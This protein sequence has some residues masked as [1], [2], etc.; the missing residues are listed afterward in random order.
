MLTDREREFR[1]RPRKPPAV[2]RGSEIG[3]W[4][5]LYKAVMRHARMTRKTKHCGR[6]SGAIHGTKRFT[7]RCAVRVTYSRNTVKGQWGA[8]GRYVARDS[9]AGGD[10]GKAGGFDSGA[11]SNAIA[12]R[13]GGWQ[14]AGDERMWKLIVSPEFGERIDL[15]RLTRELMG[16]IEQALGD[17]SLEWVAA[18]HH[19]TEHPHVHIALRGVDKDGHA[20]RLNR[21]FIKRGMREIAEDLCTRQLGYRTQLDAADAE[22]GE[23]NQYRYT[24]LDRA[25][26]R[27][28]KSSE[29]TEGGEFLRVP[30]TDPKGAGRRAGAKLPDQHILQRLIALR[31]MGLAEPVE[32]NEWRV[33]RD[34]EAVLRSMQKIGDRQKTLT[35][36]GALMS[37]P[38]LTIESMDGRDWEVLEGRVL[39]HGE[40]EDG[41]DA[42]RSYL[43]LEGTDARVHHVTYTPEIEESRNRGQLRTNSFVRLRRYIV[44][45]TPVVESEDLG[46]A[47][48]ILRNKPHLRDTAR[49]LVK[50]GVIPEE[51]G[52][53]GWL[54]RYQAALRQTTQELGQTG[55]RAAERSSGQ[56]ISRGR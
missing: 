48:A 42:G 46:D 43:M 8:H 38:R 3:A 53:G 52:W 39:V 14:Q 51:G 34:F 45:G 36:H 31:R 47:E 9:A 23:V 12:Q 1:L 7:Q 17:R 37:D 54:G 25:I 56:D 44:D 33:N 13:L 11:E 50:R 15:T 49:K 32:S 18:E 22:R 21:D 2:K 5:L 30:A 6:P 19:N 10:S 16:Q 35:A 20:L 28:A 29:G 55:K 40:E 27:S 24:S 41:R 26:T 4:S